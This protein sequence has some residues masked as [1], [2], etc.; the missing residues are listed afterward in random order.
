MNAKAQ[1]KEEAG[2]VVLETF[3]YTYDPVERFY[4]TFENLFNG[5]Q[6]KGKFCSQLLKTLTVH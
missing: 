1:L 5:D 2:F 6:Q 3:D 4:F